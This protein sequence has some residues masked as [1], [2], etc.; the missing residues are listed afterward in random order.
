MEKNMKLTTTKGKRNECYMRLKYLKLAAIGL[1]IGVAIPAHADELS[2]LKEQVNQSLQK[3]DALEKR[4][5]AISTAPAS[6]SSRP[7]V[8]QVPGT[9][10]TVKI[11]GYV[12]FTASKDVQGTFGGPEYNQFAPFSA[13]NGGI[14]YKTTVQANRNTGQVQMESRTSRI[15]LDFNT[16]TTYGNLRS[17]IEVD[18]LGTGG[19]KLQSNSTAPRLRH[20][21]A[22]FGPLLI[23]QTWTNKGDI[24]QGLNLFDVIGGPVGLSM[25]RFPQARYTFDVNPKSKLSVSIEQPVQD[26]AGADAV[27]F[28]APGTT[29]SKNTLDTMP[30]ITARYTYADTWGRQSLGV[31]ARRLKWE[32]SNTQSL[33]AAG[34]PELKSSSDIGYFVNYQGQFNLFGTDKLLYTLIYEDGDGRD[35]TSYQTSAF[36]D[37][38]G[39]L[40]TVS[41]WAGTIGYQHIWAP[42]WQSNLVWGMADYSANDWPKINSSPFSRYEKANSLH[43]NLMWSPIKNSFIGVEYCYGKIENDAGNKGIAQRVTL[44]ARFG[45]F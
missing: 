40:D 16:P 26:I 28:G 21:Y 8:F 1:S 43:A 23:G 39:D 3:I 18:F 33:T 36:I 34:R 4:Q 13:G 2:D 35:M 37:K 25:G 5:N 20:A 41:G 19:S 10:T 27:S 31:A 44:G 6:A 30:E 45:L 14:P 22:E 15:N 9:E 12:Q 17:F 42:K 11:G 29:T 32:G 38:F 7:G 24:A